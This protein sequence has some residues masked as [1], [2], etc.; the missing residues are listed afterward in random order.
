M[1]SLGWSHSQLSFSGPGQPPA[2]C[3]PVQSP[4]VHLLNANL[5]FVL[6]APLPNYNNRAILDI[7]VSLICRMVLFYFLLL[8]LLFWDRVFLWT[9]GWPGTLCRSLWPQACSDISARISPVL[10]K[11]A[12]TTLLCCPSLLLINA[13]YSSG[14]GQA[15]G[16]WDQEP[17]PLK[18]EKHSVE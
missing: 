6:K 13:W 10:G 16:C 3:Y 2:G 18:W 15:Q 7:D 8:L 14:Q 17:E 5:L 12:C 1:G 4:L 11:Q 9:P